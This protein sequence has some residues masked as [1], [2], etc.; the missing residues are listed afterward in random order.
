MSEMEKK[1]GELIQAFETTWDSFPGAARLID[2][3][4]MTIAVNQFASEHGLEAG[5]ICAKIGAPESHR[6]C[7]KN[8]AFKENVAKIDRPAQN[9]IRGWLP[10]ENYPDVVV[11]FSVGLPDVNEK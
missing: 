5:Q 7:L 11:H 8:A 9:K 4:N 1:Y 3:G 2:K 6:G 10:I